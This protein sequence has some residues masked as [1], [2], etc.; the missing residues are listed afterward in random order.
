MR[1]KS[2]SK[3]AYKIFLDKSGEFLDA[4]EHLLAEFSRATKKA[5]VYTFV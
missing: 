3:G 4:A 1:T 2:V 5:K